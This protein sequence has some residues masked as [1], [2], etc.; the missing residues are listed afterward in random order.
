MSGNITHICWT[1]KSLLLPER[2]AFIEKFGLENLQEEELLEEDNGGNVRLS[3]KEEF[4]VYSE[5]LTARTYF[6]SHC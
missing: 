1:I 4:G 5:E 3:W 2:V 6:Q